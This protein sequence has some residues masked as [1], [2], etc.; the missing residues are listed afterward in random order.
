[1]PTEQ[2]LNELFE[3][4]EISI[5]TAVRMT[6]IKLTTIS[7]Q[8]AGISIKL[9]TIQDRLTRYPSLTWLLIHKTRLTL[10][11]IAIVFFV[12]FLFFGTPDMTGLRSLIAAA[13][14]LPAP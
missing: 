2:E 4:D 11:A 13:T 3:N 14:G 6:L 7:E 5:Q 10:I 8:Q 9:D 1:M 12:V